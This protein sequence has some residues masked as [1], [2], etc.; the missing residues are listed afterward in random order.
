MTVIRLLDQH[1]Q[2]QLE[3]GIT[4]SSPQGLARFFI[5]FLYF[6][7]KEARACIFVGLFFLAVFSV[8]KAGWFSIPRYDLLLIFAILI[9]G[10][11]VA[12]KLETWDELKAVTLFHL[13]GFALEVFKTSSGIR[14]W[15]YPDFAYTKLFGVPLFAGFMYASVGS[16]IIQSWRLFDLKIRHHP[17]YWLATLVAILIYAN[18]FT[19][20]YIGDYRWYIAAL[21]V[22]LYARTTVI[23]T[24]CDRERRMPLSL[25]FILIGFFIWLAEN[26]STFFS[27]WSYPEQLGAWSMVHVGKWSSWA[28]LVIM[29]FTIVIYLKDIKKSIHVP[30]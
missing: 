21:A 8:P 26:I 4:P 7:V 3:K 18:F 23:F 5:E 22:G 13:V 1:F 15:S 24:P 28:L 29:T 14:S 2:Q 27:I 17:P 30:E 12:S 16:Y 10:W 19:H 9:Q 6:G 20:H 25:A 11:M